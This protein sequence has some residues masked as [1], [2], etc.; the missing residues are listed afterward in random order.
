MLSI[1][2]DPTT[3][4]IIRLIRSEAGFFR[5]FFDETIVAGQ[6]Q[7]GRKQRLLTIAWNTGPDQP[8]T[9]DGI[10]YTFPAHTMVP[11]VVNQTFR[12][13]RP[14]LITAWQF[15]REFYCIIDHDKEVSCSG[16]LFYGSP[17]PQFL[18][19]SEPQQPQFEALL[20]VF[21]EEFSTRD[22][23]QGDMLRMLLKRLIIKLTRLVKEQYA[24]PLPDNSL[25]LI[26]HYRMLVEQNYRRQHQVSFYAEL[27]NKSPKTLTNVFALHGQQSP[28]Q[29]IHDRIGL[30][31]KR[32]LL[33]TDKSA[34][35]IT[36]ELGFEEMPH[37]SR[38]FKNL[39]GVP[40]SEFKGKAREVLQ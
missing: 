3:N 30:E 23:I 33:Y 18:C 39:F 37:F 2:Q 35:E 31:A 32:L 17:E 40:P 29:I 12:F 34:K 24:G 8:I 26:R 4:G 21:E 28:L 15:D 25:E 1:Y 7:T 10:D 16:L 22:T 38:F 6:I 19:L 14:E 5:Q 20:T 9:I 27:L 13:A 36:Y 11:L